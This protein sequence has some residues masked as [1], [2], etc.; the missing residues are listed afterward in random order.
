MIRRAKRT[1]LAKINSLLNTY[2]LQTIDLTYINHRDVC[3]VAEVDGNI[4][5]FVWAGLMRQNKAAYL[6]YFTVSKDHA[7]QGI[8]Q[9]LAAATLKHFARIGVERAFGVIER[10]EFHDR[11][12]V[13]AL[14]MGMF[15]QERPYTYVYGFVNHSAKELGLGSN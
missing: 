6:D 7:K 13:N 15:A 10:D 5:G 14:K 4:V 11:S 8:G 12:A 1:D 2:G 9:A 3:L